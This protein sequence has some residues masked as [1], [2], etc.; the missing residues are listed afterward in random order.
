MSLGTESGDV[1]DARAE[2]DATG[3]LLSLFWAVC[4]KKAILLVRY[5]I[6]TVSQFG[7]LYIFFA[8]VFFG[9]KAVAGPE[10]TD[11][12][13]G[14]IVGFFLY[15]AALV[16][17]SGLSWNVT[18]E[19]Q[20]GTL[21]RLVM[22][23]YGFGTVVTMKVVA[24]V[25][26][27]LLWGVLLLFLMLL[28]TG[29][30]LALNVL[31][32]GALLVLSLASAVGIGFVFGG[33]ALLYKRIENVFQL[34]NFGMIALVAAPVDGYPWLKALPL[35]QG[36]AMLGRAMKNDVRLWEF[37]PAEVAIL[38]ATAVGY[39]LVGYL[40]FQRAADRARKKGVLGHY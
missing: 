37:A 5:P 40:V 17:F 11:S 28:T 39:F 18:R 20:W 25:M 22:S 12:L 36:S 4:Y 8:L 38:V 34:V 30:T 14:I 1:A 6:N 13:A 27:S 29:E 32:V 2:T 19:A 15:S 16:S 35:A 31:T 33:A 23:P 24:N 7:T 9:G 3:S 26:E 21:E 10:I